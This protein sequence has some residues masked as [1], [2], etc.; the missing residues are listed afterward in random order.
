[1][2]KKLSK[3]HLYKHDLEFASNYWK[4]PHPIFKLIIDTIPF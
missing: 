1:M 2:Y 4:L 3:H